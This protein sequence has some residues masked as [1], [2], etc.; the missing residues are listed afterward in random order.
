MRD[1]DYAYSVAYM[2]TLENKM[3]RQV[4]IDAMLQMSH[5]KESVKYL[6]D[7]GYERRDSK[8]EETYGKND[9]DQLLKDSLEDA[10][11][12][13]REVCPKEAPI[14]ILL[15]Q[16]DFHNLKAI[17]KAV[18]SGGL[19]EELM[20]M[21]CTV[22]PAFIYS[23]VSENKLDE[24][25]PFLLTAAKEAYEILA[26]KN[27]GQMAEIVID[28]ANYDAMKAVANEVRNQF[29]LDWAELWACMT[30]IK[31]ALRGAMSKKS[32]DFLSNALIPV[33][34][35]DVEKLAE[36]ASQDVSAVLS[37]LNDNNMEEAANAAQLSISEFEKWSDNEQ[38]EFIRTIQNNTFGFEPLFGF[39]YGK[40]T[41]IQDVRI[42]L[43]GQLNQIAKDVIKERLRELYA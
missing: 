12:E 3:L 6:E 31:I 41:E 10:W 2:R 25:P 5:I 17:M 34:H 15:Y 8:Q 27:D 36:A 40:R 37:F 23:A 11:R 33:R 38:M 28:K 19:W 14:D 32:K 42:V 39:L 21:P 20:L 13:I 29:L 26:A 7:K 43:Y 4:D 9:I 30:D 24:L 22:E 1:T 18:F 16:N 35:F